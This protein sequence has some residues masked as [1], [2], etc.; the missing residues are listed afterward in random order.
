MLAVTADRERVAGSV[1]VGADGFHSAVRTALHG[2]ET[3]TYA[4]YTSWR[5][6][7]DDPEGLVPAGMAIEA[8]GTGMRLGCARIDA[9]RVYAFASVNAPAGRRDPDEVASLRALFRG[10]ADP[11][12]GLLARMTPETLLHHD[13]FDRPPRRPWGR[14]RVTLL[15]DAA[16]PMTPNL[17]QGGCSAIEDAL[18]LADRLAG[19][20]DAAAALRAYE[21]A[22]YDRTERLV[23]RARW[24]GRVGQERHAVLCALRNLLVRLRPAGSMRREFRSYVD[25]R[26]DAP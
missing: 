22:R 7:V 16:H 4:G 14:G 3:P 6:I 23:R 18:V 21:S 2:P 20:T 12:P 8:W 11:W 19:T 9:Q 13:T 15:G 26:T 10:W 1:L 24:L 17:G 25:F 5:T